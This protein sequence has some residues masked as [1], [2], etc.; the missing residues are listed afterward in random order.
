MNLH[1]P[2]LDFFLCLLAGLAAFLAIEYIQKF[3]RRKPPVLLPLDGSSRIVPRMPT[4]EGRGNGRAIQSALREHSRTSR[5]RSKQA[6]RVN[7]S[8]SWEERGPRR[9]EDAEQRTRDA[10]S[11]DQI[12]PGMTYGLAVLTV[13]PSSIPLVAHPLAVGQ[14]PYPPDLVPLLFFLGLMRFHW[15]RRTPWP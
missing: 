5:R 3:C 10:K 2:D 15:R 11:M 6:A 8:K 13:G 14:A 4:E 9:A 12:T 7:I 1:N